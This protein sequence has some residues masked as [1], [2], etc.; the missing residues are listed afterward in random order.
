MAALVPMTVF[1]QASDSA[2]E[3][4]S[5]DA[6]IA[7]GNTQQSGGKDNTNSGYSENADFQTLLNTAANFEVGVQARF[8]E[9]RRELLDERASLID[10]WLA[11][12]AIVLT[13]FGVVVAIAGFVGFKKFREIEKE[14]KA[15]AKIVTDAADV[16]EHHLQEIQKKGDEAT[17]MVQK[18]HAISA[19]AN[20]KETSRTVARIQDNPDAS[21]I[22]RAVANALSLQQRGKQEDAIEKWRAIAQISEE[23][24]NE[25]AA[26]AWGS[27]GFLSPDEDLANKISSYD[28]AIQLKPNFYGAYLNRGNAKAELGRHEEAFDDF[29]MAVQLK[30][31]MAD[32]YF[33]RGIVKNRLRRHKDAIADYDKAIELKPDMA[34]AYFSRGVVKSAVERYVDAIAD[35]DIAVQLKPDMAETYFN[36]GIVKTKLGRHKDAIADFDKEIELNPDMATAYANRGISKSKLGFKVE[37]KSDLETALELFQ[38]SDNV[39]LIKEVEQILHDLSATN[40]D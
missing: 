38:N 30:P 12:I 6:E 27:V 31:D 8:N 4:T 5:S 9:I 33:N 11:V 2:I 25:L 3:V 18:L 36:R 14:A 16:A 1:S 39:D 34:E 7:A 21:L 24:D 15:S 26:R 22:D 10:W 35:F 20:P 28:R 17:R 13:F 32:T 19:D 37:G 40:G 29:D 23:S